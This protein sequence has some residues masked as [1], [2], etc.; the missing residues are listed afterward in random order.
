MASQV[1]SE[2]GGGTDFRIRFRAE[3]AAV[4]SVGVGVGGVGGGGGVTSPVTSSRPT[5]MLHDGKM[6]PTKAEIVMQ[7]DQQPLSKS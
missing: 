3:S 7:T 6:S 1:A 2:S 5:R 4:V